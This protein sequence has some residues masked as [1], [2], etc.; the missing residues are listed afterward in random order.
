MLRTRIYTVLVL[1]PLFVAALFY[2]S[3]AVWALLLAP[4]VLAGA[5]EWGV[6]A[7]WR[8]APRMVYAL[9]I[10]VSGVLLWRF[11]YDDAQS[12][13]HISNIILGLSLL[14]WLVV[15]PLWLA[16]GWRVQAPLAMAVAGAI[17]L[18]PL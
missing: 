15:A 18:V 14:F 13:R 12:A 11:G 3:A 16:K 10:A 1:L 4:L 7:G 5:W 6:L 2:T 9:V 8:P 17:L